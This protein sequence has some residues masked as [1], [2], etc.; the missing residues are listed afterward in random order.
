MSKYRAKP[1]I[2]D[3]IRFASQKEARRY[4]E[5]RLL[6]RSGE[7][8]FLELQPRF[9]FDI[10]GVKLGFYKADF[11]YIQNGIKITEDSKGFSTPVFKLKRKLLKALHGVDLLIT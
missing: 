8:G 9:D 5:L 6:E 3:N 4:R 7:I 10:N 1:E 11:R 2:V